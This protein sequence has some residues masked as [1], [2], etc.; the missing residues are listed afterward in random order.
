METNALVFVSGQPHSFQIG[1]T[2]PSLI[3]SASASSS[4]RG[5]A[6]M[7]WRT[8]GS[9]GATGTHPTRTPLT[10]R[11]STSS[12]DFVDFTKRGKCIP[13]S[14]VFA[15]TS[16]SSVAAV[17]SASVMVALVEGRGLARGEIGMAS[18]NLRCPE[19]VL[20]QFADTG[21]YAKVSSAFINSQSSLSK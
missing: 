5:H 9:V 16:Y 21:T 13:D 19:L 6:G 20:S 8:S 2:N 10:D 17:S 3:A 18:L 4:H 15:A 11:S 7:C 12:L 1:T 14:T